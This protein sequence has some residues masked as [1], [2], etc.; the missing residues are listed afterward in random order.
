MARI[1]RVVIPGAPHHVTQR[2]NNKQLSFRDRDD[3]LRYLTILRDSL[4]RQKVQILAFSLMPNHVH[5]VL[6]PPDE[7]SLSE[8]LRAAHGD[9][10]R[11]FNRKYQRSGHLWQNRFFSCP[12]ESRHLYRA[13]RYVE[14]NPVRAGLVEEAWE[15]EWSTASFHCGLVSQP[16][17]LKCISE[18]G[19][20]EV[21][22]WDHYLNGTESEVDR[23]SIR[24]S[25][26]SGRL[27]GSDT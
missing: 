14:L 12:L 20:L 5:Q 2:G 24:A 21:G 6:I 1:A 26:A 25:T 27:W 9:Y 11:A 18:F 10:A 16:P 4:E 8:A 15:Y 7:T 19:T 17:V 22:D 23:L 13:I 3:H